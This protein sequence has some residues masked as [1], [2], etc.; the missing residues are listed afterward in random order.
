M[1]VNVC[2]EIRTD[3]KLRFSAH[4]PTHLALE[5]SSLPPLSTLTSTFSSSSNIH[6]SFFLSL[7]FPSF[8]YFTL[9]Q[10]TMVSESF[11]S[12]SPIP[13]LSLLLHTRPP[14]SSSSRNLKQLSSIIQWTG[15]RYTMSPSLLDRDLFFP[16]FVILLLLFLIF[17]SPLILLFILHPCEQAPQHWF[18]QVCGVCV[19]VCVC[20]FSSKLNSD[21]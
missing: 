13:L 20:V 4:P 7:F 6:I 19:Y 16:F 15:R 8:P 10:S 21:K 11:L 2:A 18:T 14:S 9:F 1:N 3:C 17:S 5:D 12:L